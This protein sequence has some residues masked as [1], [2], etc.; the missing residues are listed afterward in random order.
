MAAVKGG[1]ADEAGKF[2]AFLQTPE[3]HAVFTR[4]G[5]SLQ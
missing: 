1:R 4:L 3:A 2:L 5:F